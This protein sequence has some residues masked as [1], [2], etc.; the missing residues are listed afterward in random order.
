MLTRRT[1][2]YFAA[3]IQ[4]FIGCQI[5][6]SSDVSDSL[7]PVILDETQLQQSYYSADILPHCIIEF[8]PAYADETCFVEPNEVPGK[9]LQIL[10]RRFLTNVERLER[11]GGEYN[12]LG[13]HDDHA[14]FDEAMCTLGFRGSCAL[15][16]LLG[17]YDAEVIPADALMSLVAGREV[18]YS[19]TP[20]TIHP[21]DY[22]PKN[23]EHFCIVIKNG[24]EIL[25]KELDEWISVD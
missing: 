22:D 5:S 16:T 15:Q 17:Q 14:L 19:E 8:A 9:E 1:R 25:K 18:T 4:I 20:G 13:F 3:L 7:S 6:A 24:I 11:E 12:K 21:I 23:Y 10:H 2:Q